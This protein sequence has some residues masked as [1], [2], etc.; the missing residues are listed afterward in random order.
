MPSWSLFRK[1]DLSQASRL[2]LQQ[3]ADLF[4]AVLEVARARVALRRRST[5]DLLKEA[6]GDGAPQMCV[7]VGSWVQRVSWAVPVAAA[8]VPWRSDCFIQAMAAR[9]WLARN[10]VPTELKI[11]VCKDP[12]T[13]FEAHAWLIAEGQVIIG[14]DINR[15]V[16]LE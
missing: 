2:S 7:K 13:G 16:V 3:W 12:I 10:G 11:G 9:R 1:G 8:R 4:T 14:G 5:E 15:F 6:Q